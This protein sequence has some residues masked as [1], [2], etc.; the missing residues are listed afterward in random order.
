[1]RIL[2]T[3][4]KQPRRATGSTGNG[5]KLGGQ[6]SR[7]ARQTHA[8]MSTTG[9]SVMIANDD[10]RTLAGEVEYGHSVEHH[11][12]EQEVACRKDTELGP[13]G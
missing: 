9:N 12:H 4:R 11:R 6:T 5:A 7:Q 2:S 13:S 8:T 10:L 1:M 3:V